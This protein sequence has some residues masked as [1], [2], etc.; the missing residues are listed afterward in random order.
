VHV[1]PTDDL[2]TTSPSGNL[3]CYLERG[4]RVIYEVSK[5]GMI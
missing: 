5:F 3:E 1:A 4:G 2:V